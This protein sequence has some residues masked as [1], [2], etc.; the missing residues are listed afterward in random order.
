[1]P[2]ELTSC[3]FIPGRRRALRSFVAAALLP[4]AHAGAQ[5]QAM[6]PTPSQ[7]EGPFYPK[8]FPADRD[9][10]LTQIAG[11]KAKATGT[12]ALFHRP[13]AD[14]RRSSG[15]RRSRRIVAVRCPRPLSPRGRRRRSARRQFPGL[16]RRHHGRRGSL[17]L[18]DHPAGG[19][20]GSAA[21]PAR[22]G[23]PSRR[24]HA[25][26]A[27]LHLRRR[28]RGRS[29][30]IGY[31]CT[32]GRRPTAGPMSFN[33]KHPLKGPPGRFSLCNFLG[34]LGAADVH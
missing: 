12:H 2:R 23:A 5:S 10:D 28:G 31:L 33:R 18:Q 6:A 14:P 13:R 19:L 16:W 27:D 21:A 7:P 4:I 15:R 11:R 30:R 24:R 22:E 26:D 25:H 17:R 8:S 20:H 29:S 1:M 32:L 34:H 3:R 9:S